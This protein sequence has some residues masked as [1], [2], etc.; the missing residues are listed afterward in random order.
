MQKSANNSRRP[1]PRL[2]QSGAGHPSQGAHALGFRIF[3]QRVSA[4]LPPLGL[5][6]PPHSTGT[7]ARA[8][9]PHTHTPAC[10]MA[11]VSESGSAARAPPFELWV[12]VSAANALS[13][14]GPELQLQRARANVRLRETPPRKATPGLQ[15]GWR[16]GR[17][18]CPGRG[19]SPL[20]SY[21]EWR[22]ACG[23][24]GRPPRIR[25]G[26]WLRGCA[27]AQSRRP[28]RPQPSPTSS[29]SSS[30]VSAPPYH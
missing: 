6:A 26:P 17:R 9:P 22:A 8:P 15:R 23:R 28:A 5:P 4:L 21:P 19:P 2:L 14:R 18:R 1:L 27:V 20:R 3:L 29:S 16:S 12:I 11:R 13:W 24:W 25:R 7:G 10:R 30:S